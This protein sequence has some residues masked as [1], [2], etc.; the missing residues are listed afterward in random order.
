MRFFVGVT[1]NSWF[2]FHAEKQ[3]DEVNFWRPRSTMGFRA[4]QCGEPFLFKLHSPLN[5]IAG[6]GFFVRHSVL[7]VSLAWKAFGEKTGASA[8]DLISGNLAD[9][10]FGP[11]TA[12]SLA[13]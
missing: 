8:V 6:G 4:I 11:N 2:R 3:P 13:S 7:P 9:Y 10:A 12:G 1:D 5:F